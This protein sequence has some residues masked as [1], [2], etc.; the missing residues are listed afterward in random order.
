MET[1]IVTINTSLNLIIENYYRPKVQT[2]IHNTM[3]GSN[4]RKEFELNI[5]Q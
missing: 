5:N 3:G 1:P 2:R 4:Y